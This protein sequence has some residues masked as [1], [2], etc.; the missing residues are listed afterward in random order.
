MM[1]QSDLIHAAHNYFWDVAVTRSSRLIDQ[2]TEMFPFNSETYY[3]LTEEFE[4]VERRFRRLQ[5]Y[6]NEEARVLGDMAA[7]INGSIWRLWAAVVQAENRERRA[8]PRE[9]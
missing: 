2:P 3:R 6:G 5:L 8:A 7:E 1:F 4:E 9:I